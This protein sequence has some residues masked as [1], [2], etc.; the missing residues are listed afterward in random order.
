MAGAALWQCKVQIPWQAQHFRKVRYRLRGRHSTFAR[1][2]TDFAA[3][4]AHSK[5]RYRSRGR[6]NILNL[7]KHSENQ[8]GGVGAAAPPM[9]LKEVMI[10]QRVMM[11]EEVMIQQRVR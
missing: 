1:S 8:R 9:M 2:A 6:R 4:A 7:C 11:I 10:Q 3:G 5:V